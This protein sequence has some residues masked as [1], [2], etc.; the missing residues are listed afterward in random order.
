MKGKEIQSV[1]CSQGRVAIV[2]RNGQKSY[3]KKEEVR[4]QEN[5]GSRLSR[6]QSW[7]T[8][9]LLV[10]GCLQE[11]TALTPLQRRVGREPVRYAYPLTVLPRGQGE[12]RVGCQREVTLSKA[13]ALKNV[14]KWLLPSCQPC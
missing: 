6:P 13:L 10:V 1:F 12:A 2:M 14:P 4:R 3:R 7:L 11:V 8:A 5:P 9:G